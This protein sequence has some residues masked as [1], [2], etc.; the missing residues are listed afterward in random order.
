LSFGGDDVFTLDLALHND[1]TQGK[2]Y[3]DM[4]A[5]D[6]EVSLQTGCMRVVFL[7]K[8]VQNLLVSLVHFLTVFNG[9]CSGVMVRIL[10]S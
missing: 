4:H 3:I 5:F 7:N 10:N 8:F 6:V 9:Q 1:G 2:K